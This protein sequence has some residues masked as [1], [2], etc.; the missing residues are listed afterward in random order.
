MRLLDSKT[1]FRMSP[2]TVGGRR[3]TEARP[4]KEEKRAIVDM[5]RRRT[6]KCKERSECRIVNATI[7][8]TTSLE[9]ETDE[10]S[11]PD[12]EISRPHMCEGAEN[13]LLPEFVEDVAFTRYGR[14]LHRSFKGKNCAV[15]KGTS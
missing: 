6:N 7:P 11:G 9:G 12:I 3:P 10:E 2:P 1:W 14:S 5:S 15:V 13:C 4:K 8:T